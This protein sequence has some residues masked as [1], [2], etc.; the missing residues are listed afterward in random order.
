[1]NARDPSCRIRQAFTLGDEFSRAFIASI[2]TKQHFIKDCEY[3]D[4]WHTWAGLPNEIFANCVGKPINPRSGSQSKIVGRYAD[5]LCSTN[6]GH[7][8][9]QKHDHIKWSFF[10][11]MKDSSYAAQC[12]PTGLFRQFAQTNSNTHVAQNTIRK[13]EIIQ[14]DFLI[15]DSTQ[16]LG[17]IKTLSYTPSNYRGS[18]GTV[19]G[20]AV[21]SRAARVHKDMHRTAMEADRKWNNTQS[22]ETGPIADRLKQYGP[23]KGYVFGYLGEASQDVRDEIKAMAVCGAKNLWRGMGLSDWQEAHDILQHRYTKFMGIAAVRAIARMRFRVWGHIF[24]NDRITRCSSTAEND[25]RHL[26]ARL[27]CWDSHRPSRQG[28]LRNLRFG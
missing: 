2:P 24:S 8:M 19:C 12:E 26:E 25:R 16:H 22:G 18:F 7:F 20:K 28:T 10:Q 13:R 17:D 1:M 9:T 27:T 15:G 6:L 5:E 3:H 11:L 21:S 4:V 23:I 14:P